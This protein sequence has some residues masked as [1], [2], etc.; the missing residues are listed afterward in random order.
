MNKIHEVG[1]ISFKQAFKDFWEGF[2]DFKGTSTLFG[3]WWGVI[4]YIITLTIF[5]ILN[6]L[7]I[8]TLFATIGQK[9]SVVTILF[10]ISI[11]MKF[12]I[13]IPLLAAASRRLHDTGIKNVTILFLIVGYIILHFISLI[14]YTAKFLLFILGIIILIMCCM[15]RGKFS[16][17]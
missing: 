3:F 12:V 7:A 2:F 8:I 14:A 9:K 17:K 6:G 16:N 10:I 4:V 15:P 5:N 1:E 11:I 13:L